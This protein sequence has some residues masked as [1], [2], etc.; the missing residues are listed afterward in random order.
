M[1]SSF[2]NDVQI[3]DVTNLMG[4]KV[5]IEFGT[6]KKKSKSTYVGLFLVNHA[7]SNF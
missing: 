5:E 6:L 4:L 2:V 7:K 1:F 3:C